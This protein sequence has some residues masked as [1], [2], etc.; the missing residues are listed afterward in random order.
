MQNLGIKTEKP[1][2]T[3]PEQLSPV[4]EGYTRIFH[5]SSAKECTKH[6]GKGHTVWVKGWHAGSIA[7][8]H[9]RSKGHILFGEVNFAI[10]FSPENLG[11]VQRVFCLSDLLQ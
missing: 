8:Y 4:K 11:K 1:V 10:D 2:V 6:S 5:G 9:G 3:R 7:V